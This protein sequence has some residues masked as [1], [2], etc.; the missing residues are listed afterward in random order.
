MNYEPHCFYNLYFLILGERKKGGSDLGVAEPTFRP[1]GGDR[2]TLNIFFF[3]FFSFFKKINFGI[4][5]FL[6]KKKIY[7]YFLIP[8]GTKTHIIHVPC[9]R[10]DMYQHFKVGKVLK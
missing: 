6:K 9:E 4:F 8:C 1:N 2:I 3:N 5:F 10:K 7:I